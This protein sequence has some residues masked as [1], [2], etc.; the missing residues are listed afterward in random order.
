VEK[1]WRRRKKLVEMMW[2]VWG[3]ARAMIRIAKVT[4]VT[5]FQFFARD[6]RA[7][8]IKAQ[9]PPGKP[10]RSLRSKVLTVDLLF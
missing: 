4:N 6:P 2:I 9:R 10:L 8:N 5:N 7:M 1:V 3:K